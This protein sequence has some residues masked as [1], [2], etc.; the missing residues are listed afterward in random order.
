[1]RSGY[2]YKHGSISVKL[3]REAVDPGE[4]TQGDG[5]SGIFQDLGLEEKMWGLQRTSSVGG[6][7]Q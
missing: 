2:R 1:M 3:V 4:R 5:S 7:Q 6:S